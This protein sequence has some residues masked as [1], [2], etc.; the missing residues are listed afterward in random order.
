M[1]QLQTLSISHDEGDDTDTPA[2]YR[3]VQIDVAIKHDLRCYV[4]MC[5]AQSL[6]T[7]E[8]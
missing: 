4:R 1:Y 3:V 8:N 2:V 7:T 5:T 6:D